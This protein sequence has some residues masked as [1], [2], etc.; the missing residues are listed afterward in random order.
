VNDRTAVEAQARTLAVRDAATKAQQLADAAG[1]RLGPLLSLTEQ[2]I[3]RPIP[4]ARGISAMASM[5]VEPGEVEV[6]VIVEARY[7]LGR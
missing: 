5:P 3:G 7:R 1:V 6:T 4:V 2:G